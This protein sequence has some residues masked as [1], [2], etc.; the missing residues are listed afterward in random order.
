MK[1]SRWV[2]AATA[3]VA[4][5]LLAAVLAPTAN[6]A[7]ARTFSTELVTRHSN[8]CVSV[9]GPSVENRAALVQ[10]GCYEAPSQHWRFVAT[11]TPGYY[12]LRATHS[13]RCLSISG[14][15]I[16]EGATAVQFDCVDA[17]N[18]Q[19]RL[20]QKDSGFFSLEARHS[21]KCL[22][23]LAASTEDGAA[24]VQG[25]CMERPNQHFRLA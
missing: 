22:S 15:S 1:I 10:H 19:W 23:V 6:A 11:G 7:E 14:G 21:G 3:V 5:F 4:A 17:R 8:K 16:D 2:S 13:G 9:T 24:M 20:V 25:D 18:Q 12:T